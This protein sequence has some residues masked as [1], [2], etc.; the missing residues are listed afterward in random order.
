MIFWREAWL[1]KVEDNVSSQETRRDRQSTVSHI[2]SDVREQLRARLKTLSGPKTYFCQASELL[3]ATN[4]LSRWERF[5]KSF[6]EVHAGNCSSLEM[7]QRIGIWLFWRIRRVFLGAYARGTNKSTPAGG[8]NLQPGEW[9]EVEPM[10]SITETLNESAQTADCTL[11]RPCALL[12]GE[13][14]RVEKKVDKIIVDGTGE[15]RQLRNTVFLEGSLCG[16]ACVAFGGC[17]RGEFAYWREIWLR[18]SA[19]LA[20][21]KPLNTES[22][23]IPER[24]MSTT[25]CVEKEQ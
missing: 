20:A 3:N 9:V 6:S 10:E 15:M 25:G 8:I 22:W 23:H 12:C 24:V 2:D 1:R 14:H 21:A 18:R 7:A 19:G 16:C 11:R 17:P 5:G 4:E 13:Q